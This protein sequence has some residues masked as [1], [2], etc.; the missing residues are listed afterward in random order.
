MMTVE[1]FSQHYARVW[2]KLVKFTLRYVDCQD[3]AEDV[4]SDVWRSSLKRLD[5]FDG[6]A[7]DRLYLS[8]QQ[9]CRF[10]AQHWRAKRRRETELIDQPVMDRHSVEFS[11]D[12]LLSELRVSL[13]PLARGLGSGLSYQE[14]ARKLQQPVSA[15]KVRIHRMRRELRTEGLDARPVWWVPIYYKPRSMRDLWRAQHPGCTPQTTVRISTE[16]YRE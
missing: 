15:V 13:R 4:V 11:V 10:G 9:S 14:I 8:L 5:A 16:V 7:A 3:D 12:T 6:M 2:S 1:E